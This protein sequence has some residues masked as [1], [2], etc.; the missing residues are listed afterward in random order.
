MSLLDGKIIPL[1]PE[2]ANH[3]VTFSY[4]YKYMVDTYSRVDLPPVIVV[5]SV[6]DG[7]I[8]FSLEKQP[9]I[10]E[11]IKLGWQ[12]PEVFSAKGRDGV[13]DIWGVIVRPTNFDPSRSYP[14][15]EYIY[16]GPHDSHVPKSF[17]MVHRCS[18]LA[19]LGFITVM[20]DGMGTANRSKAFH[21][22]CW[23]NL[24]DA[25]FP[26]RIEWIKAAAKKYPQMNIEKVG[27]YES[28]E[29]ECCGPESPIL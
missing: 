4:D 27:I 26:D 13:T 21:D 9:N 14:V 28:N 16:A 6:L 25:G 10:S 22:V 11:A 23:R 1:T 20:I 18:E 15:I 24:K 3:K 29:I 8:I 19:E 5:R 7:T 2:N 12:I 17:S